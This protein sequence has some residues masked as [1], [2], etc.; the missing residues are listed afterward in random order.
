MLVAKVPAVPVDGDP[1]DGLDPRLTP[2]GVAG[3]CAESAHPRMALSRGVPGVAARPDGCRRSGFTW[4]SGHGQWTCRDKPGCIWSG[5]V[6]CIRP[7]CWRVMPRATVLPQR[8]VKH[9]RARSHSVE[10]LQV[11][12]CGNEG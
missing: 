4:D 5:L 9:G 11:M 6:R 12:T 8:S 2:S 1:R 3:R 10:A 7:V